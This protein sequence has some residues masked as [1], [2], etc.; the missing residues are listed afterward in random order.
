MC[1]NQELCKFSRKL[2]F[3][4]KNENSS[5]CN[6]Y[7]KTTRIRQFFQMNFN[8]DSILLKPLFEAIIETL[9]KD[10]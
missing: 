2:T 10:I 4:W 5:G 3:D 7:N 1:S 6:I 9:D 8:Y